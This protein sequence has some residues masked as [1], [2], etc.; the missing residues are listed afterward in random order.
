MEINFNYIQI[1]KL[2]LQTNR[3]EKVKEKKKGGHL[4]NPHVFF[5]RYDP[6]IG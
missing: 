3:V 2:M 1:Q 6:Q 4:S 5:L